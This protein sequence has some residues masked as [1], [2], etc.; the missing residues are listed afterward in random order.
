MKPTG[1]PKKVLLIV[2]I[3]FL[4]SAIYL[5]LIQGEHNFAHLP[6]LTVTDELGEISYRTVEPYEFLDQNG[7]P[8]TQKKVD[9]KIHVVDFFFTRCPSI[10]QIM[11]ENMKNLHRKFNMYEDFALISHTV[12][13]QYDTTFVLKNYARERSI[14]FENWHFVTGNKDSIYNT[15]FEYLSSAMEDSAAPG[16]FLHTEYFVLL[17]KEGRIRSREDDNGN[18]IGVYDGTSKVQV[19]NLIDDIKVLMA[20]YQLELKKNN[21]KDE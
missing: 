10:C 1:G 17:D 19:N 9:G 18:I 2:I 11:T 15:A 4:P 5:Y 21:K 12:D 3:L 14:D 6:M 13:P 16:G 8:F 20:E 7:E